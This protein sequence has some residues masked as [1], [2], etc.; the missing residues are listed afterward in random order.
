MQRYYDLLPHRAVKDFA[1]T[2]AESLF[3]PLRVV[4]VDR[5]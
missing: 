4:R 1:E 5:L 2:D 3:V